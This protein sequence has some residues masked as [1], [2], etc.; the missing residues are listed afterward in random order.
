MKTGAVWDCEW[1]WGENCHNKRTKYG[2]GGQGHAN[3]AVKKCR[4]GRSQYRFN[5]IQRHLATGGILEES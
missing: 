5:K 3:I 4:N 1:G 2:G